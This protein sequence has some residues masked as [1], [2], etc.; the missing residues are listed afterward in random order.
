MS[1]RKISFLPWGVEIHEYVSKHTYL[2]CYHGADIN[3]IRSINGVI[4]ANVY[5]QLFVL[6]PSLKEQV[7]TSETAAPNL[8]SAPKSRTLKNVDIVF[9]NGVDATDSNN[10]S[11]VATASHVAFDILK[12]TDNKI[13]IKVQAQYLDD[14]A[15][16]DK[17]KAIHEVHPTRL[18]NDRASTILHANINHLGTNYQGEGEVVAVADTGY[19]RG[20]LDPHLTLPAFAPDKIR[21]LYALGRPAE[22]GPGRTDDPDGHGT[23]VCGSIVG[24]GVF[25]GTTIES[26]APLASLVVQSLID[27]TNGLGGIPPNL[28]TLFNKPYVDD[29]ARIHTNS[30]GY[31]YNG[32]QLAYDPSS[33]EIDRF[34]WEHP[35]MVICFAAGNDGRDNFPAN[36]IIDLAQI[37]AHAAAKNCITVGASESDRGNPRTY[38]SV[39]PSEYPMPPIR[40]DPIADDANGMAAFSSRGPTKEGRIKPDVVAPGTSI[41]SARSRASSLS[42]SNIWGTAGG[43]WVFMGGTSMATPLVA[44]C[45][46]VLRQTLRDPQR[47]YQPSAALIKALLINGATELIGQYN[48]PETGQS[49]NPNSGWGRVNLANSVVFGS[50]PDAGY[51]EAGPLKQGDEREVFS[52]PIPIGNKHL[53]VTLVWTDPPG[54]CLQNDLN[55]TVV[56]DGQER[57]GNMGSNPGY[58]SVNNVEQ[59]SWVSIPAGEAK[60]RVRAYRITKYPQ[61]YACA[62]KL[63]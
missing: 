28:E 26:P 5:P 20:S 21:Q 27:D 15:A 18:F 3:V 51:V 14:I 10:K 4:W 43:D 61:P 58:D 37:G 25:D 13:R 34:V 19:D 35:E 49:P 48:P 55:L 7:G 40:N 57:H 17:V 8:A 62:W 12:P 52:I 22:A 45:V 53:K 11:A 31:E 9:H 6:P 60:V 41:L 47:G 30:W 59:V 50:Q 1:G 42:P 54:P 39:W 38:H 44:G 29:K 24:N 23:H 46:A 2:C 16:L 32:S 56:V 63:V 36:G 33:A